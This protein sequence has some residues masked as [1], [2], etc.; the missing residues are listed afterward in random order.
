MSMCVSWIIN[1]FPLAV[2]ITQPVRFS[3]VAVFCVND[4]K[5]TPEA[6]VG[7]TAGENDVENRTDLGLC[8]GQYML[9]VLLLISNGSLCTFLSMNLR[10]SETLPSWPLQSLMV[11]SGCQADALVIFNSVS[12][13]SIPRLMHY[14]SASISCVD[15]NS[16]KAISSMT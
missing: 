4:L 15:G 16:M 3:R 2:F 12:L 1:T 8:H 9:S 10:A 6:Q 5:L 11:K 14:G 13:H 7:W